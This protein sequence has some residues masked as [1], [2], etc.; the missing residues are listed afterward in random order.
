L[1]PIFK[2][3]LISEGVSEN[4]IIK[5]D[6]DE[7]RNKKYQDPDVLDE[8]IRSLIVDE[9]TYYLLLD[10][11][12]KV[13]DFES[14]LNG[15]LHIRNLD[16]YVTGSN[17]KFLSSDIIT[18]FRGRGDEIRVFPLSFSEYYSVFKGEKDEAWDEYITY[19]GLPKIVSINGENEKA[20]YLKQ[21]FEK[22]YLSDIVERNNIQRI[23]IIDS[24]LNILSSSIGS[25]TNPYKLLKTFQ[26]NCVKDISINTISSYLKYLQDS[27]LINKAERYDIKGKKY[28]Q[29]PFKFYFSDIGLR[30][31]RLNFRQQEETHIM[32]NV[33]Y[34]ELLIRG[35]NVDVGV[36]NIR[37]GDAKKQIEVDFVCNQ[38][39]KKYY[40]QSA[41]SL[42][43]HEKT[44]QEERPLLNIQDNFKKI[45]IVKDSKKAWIT[46]EGIL[47]IGIFE[48]LL[49]KNSLDL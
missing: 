44:V 12:Q 36:V 43:T 15:F 10:E 28:I 23:D 30:N 21:L 7:R 33:I 42:P 14:V 40:I 47:V 49:N 35:Y 13:D 29:S 17:S 20:K 27:F 22:T 26:S 38:F 18:E 9:E 1:D 8:Y 34:N 46:E 11:V 4:H 32:E 41:L 37:E 39:N 16:I 6:L 19:G 2:E 31:A 24:I 48:F 5:I 25:L 3:Y 45:I